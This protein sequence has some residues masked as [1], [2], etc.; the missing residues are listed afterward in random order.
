MTKITRVGDF[1]LTWGESV[2]WD[3]QRQRLYFVDCAAHQLHWLDEAVAPLQSLALPSMPTGVAL[4]HDGRLVV[5]LDDGLHVVDPD[6]GGTELL[7]PYPEEM[8]GRANDAAADLDGNL[9]TGSLSAATRP[10]SYWWFSAGQGW[11]KLDEG[12]TNANGPVVLQMGGAQTLVIADTFA[13]VLY[14]HEYDGL[15]GAVGARRSFADT[16]EFGALPD[17]ACGDA[18]GGV[19]SCLLGPGKIVRYTT[20]GPDFQIDVPVD[21][22]SDA[23][24]G[25]PGLDRLF[26]VSIGGGAD[27]GEKSANAGAVMVVD[28]LPFRGR[29]EPRVRLT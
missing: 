24:F 27:D 18:Q 15:A 2:R 22:P 11:R 16:R 13:S 6:L 5:A 8:G 10:G 20:D 1:A 21:N 3:D 4:C 29:P 7:S 14:A 26:F 28:G 17:G 25:G 9:V 23:T 12:I 19:W